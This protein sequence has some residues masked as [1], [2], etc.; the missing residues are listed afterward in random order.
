[1]MQSTELVSLYFRAHKHTSL[2]AHLFL[3]FNFVMEVCGAF[4]IRFSE[5]LQPEVMTAHIHRFV[6]WQWMK[7][8]NSMDLFMKRTAGTP[9]LDHTQ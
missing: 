5:G 4:T 9:H 7:A 3:N 8:E 6:H 1:M 2:T